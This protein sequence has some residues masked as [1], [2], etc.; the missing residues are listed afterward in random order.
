MIIFITDDSINYFS[1]NRL[2]IQCRLQ[3]IRKQWDSALHKFWDKEDFRFSLFCQTK[4]A[5]DKGVKFAILDKTE[6]YLHEELK[7]FRL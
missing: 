4:S 2:I 7:Q 5:K 1:I 6:S 3:N